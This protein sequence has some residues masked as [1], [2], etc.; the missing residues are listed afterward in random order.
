MRYTHHNVDR[1]YG[2]HVYDVDRME[3]LREVVSVDTEAGELEVSVMPLTIGPDGN[4]LTNRL[5]FRS[6]Y[7]I[8]G[9][10]QYPTLFHCYGRLPN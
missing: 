4:T 6:I 10:G 8:F 1:T 3:E 2:A 5:R 9:G 7:P